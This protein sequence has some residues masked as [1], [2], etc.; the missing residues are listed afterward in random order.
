MVWGDGGA[1]ATWFSGE[2]EMIQG[3]NLLPVTGGHLY[4]GNDPAYVRTNY[5]E[6]VRNNG[7]QPTVWQDI[8]WQFQA[9]GDPDAALANLRANPGYTLRGRAGHTPSTGSAT[10]RPWAMSTR[11]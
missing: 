4:L 5:A 9:L 8:L 3:I 1:Y 7:G 10:S 6:L 2:P 11:R